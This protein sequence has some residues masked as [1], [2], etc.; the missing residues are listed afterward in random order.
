MGVKVTTAPCLNWSQPSIPH[1]S[2]SSSL[3][4]VSSIR[5]QTSL[6]LNNR[7]RSYGTLI[8]GGNKHR[9]KRIVSATFDSPYSDDDFDGKFRLPENDVINS[10][11]NHSGEKHHRE[12]ELDNGVDGKKLN[13]PENDVIH[14]SE[15]NSDDEFDN[16]IDGF[17]LKFR[18][19]E[20][21][22]VDVTKWV[23]DM[24]PASI[25]RKAS[26][27]S[28]PLSLRI[29][30]KK[31]QL[32]DG[33][34]EAGEFAYCSMQ[35][36]FSSM[37]FIIRELQS[38]TLQMREVLFLEDLQGILIRVQKEMNASFV[39]LFQQVFSHTPN[40]MVCVMILLAN[41]SVYSMS[42]H[43]AAPPLL[44]ATVESVSTVVD[45]SKLDFLN[46]GGGGKFR[47]VSGTGG[48][49]KFDRSERYRTVVPDGDSL[50]AVN[51][52]GAGDGSVSGEVSEVEELGLWE[53][54][55]AEAEEM[56]GVGGDGG[57]DG[58]AR[59]R[60]VSPVTVKA[61]EEV[62]A[63]EYLKTELVYQMGL[64]KEPENSLLLA[65]YAQFLYM[66]S[67]DHKRAEE[68]FKKAS[69]IE[70]KDAEALSKYGCFLWHAKNDLWAAEETLLEA[71]SI[72][73]NNPFYSAT[74]AQFLWSN[75]ARDTCFLLESPENVNSDEA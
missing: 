24:I 33:L 46:S 3:T 39:W 16:G 30:Q 47:R 73:P 45:H 59:R 57:L 10:S 34:I 50:P 35:K 69:K 38:Y 70:P 71:I 2:S 14:S 72:E 31:K 49:G 62:D 74:Y 75:G 27:V 40:L 42:A 65:N 5:R 17:G 32:E 13:I 48:D 20:N 6:T 67:H 60:F 41:Y 53:S 52:A 11:E 64:L 54:V 43:A 36:A 28:L 15:N 58:E 23:G 7:S 37:V 12:D 29:I 51:P 9:I 63:G 61:E 21:D 56:R 18:S 68:Y 55:V 8:L 1:S 19:P 44:P 4:L 22:S 26:S 66:F 25:E